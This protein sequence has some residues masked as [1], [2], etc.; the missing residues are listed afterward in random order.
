MPQEPQATELPAKKTSAL[1]QAP[2]IR[3]F[4]EL[5]SG[6][7]VTSLAMLINYYGIDVDKMELADRMDK[8]ETP[9]RLRKDGSIAYWGNPNIG[10]VGD[11]TGKSRGF[12]IY[13]GPLL[14]LMKQYIPTAV[15]LTEKPFEDIERQVSEGIPVIVW[16]TINFVIPNNWV[17]WDSPLGPIRTTF[18]EHAVLLVG[19]DEESV[20][21]NDPWTGRAAYKVNKERFIATWEAMGRQAISYTL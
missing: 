13:H 8:D 16:T 18:S 3:Q 11:V 5:R 7:E 9:M 1:L 12:G 6:C 17:V 20:Y 21:V 2:I 4:P 10:F 19:Y 15:D 14:N